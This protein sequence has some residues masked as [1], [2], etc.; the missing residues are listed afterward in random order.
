MRL[1]GVAAIEHGV[2]LALPRNITLKNGVYL[3]VGAYLH[4]CP[5]GIEIGVNTLVMYHS[6]LHVYNFRSMPQSGIRIGRDCLIGEF[7][8][9]RGQGGVQIGD[10]VYLSPNVQILAVNHVF[11]N[12][13]IPIIQQGITA[14]GIVIEDDAWIGAGAIILDG[15]NIGA[16]S[17]VAAGS[18]V[19]EDV[20]PLAI[21]AG[22]PARQIGDRRNASPKQTS[23]AIYHGSLL[24]LGA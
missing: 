16:G 1:Q 23:E 22:V 11:D 21:V 6:I 18:V 13:D 20:Q 24:D 4:A 15:I 10:R 7:S 8:V 14:K 17:V 12:P 5:N 3:D 19:T 2:R 9:I